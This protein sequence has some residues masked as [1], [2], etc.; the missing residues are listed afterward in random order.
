MEIQGSRFRKGLI[1]MINYILNHKK[2]A[3]AG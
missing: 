3:A 1:I 2:R